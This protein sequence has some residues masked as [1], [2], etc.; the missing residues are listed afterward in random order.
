M[1]VSKNTNQSKPTTKPAINT[2]SS[3]YQQAA[4]RHNLSMSEA[5]QPYL[6]RKLALDNLDYS[7]R[8][9]RGQ[10]SAAE[11]VELLFDKGTFTEI[12]PLARES[13]LAANTKPSETPRDGIVVGYGKVNGRMVGAA[14]Y[15]IQFRGGSMGKVCEW[16]FTRLKRLIK[17]QGFPLVIMSEGTGARLEEEVSSQGAY[18]N[19]QFTNLVALSGYVPIV[20]AVMGVCVGGHA[21]LTAIG[22][23]VPMTENSSMMLAGPPLLRTKMGVDTTLEELGGARKHVEQSGMGDLLVKDDRECIEK[24][25]EFLGYLPNNCQEPAPQRH[26]RDNPERRCEALLEVVPS[27]LRFAYDIKKVVTEL[28][29]DGRFFEMQ[30]AFAPNVVTALAHMGGRAVGVIANQ[31][32]YMSG[33]IDVKAC[34]KISRFINFCDCFGIALVFLQDIPGFYPGPQSEADGIIRWSTR[35]LYEIGH[36]TVPRLTVMLRKAFGLA[37][38]GMNSLGMEPDLLVAWPLASFS[39]ISP[40]DAVEIMFGKQLAQ[41]EDGEQRKQELIAEFEAKTTILPAAEAALVDDVIDPRDTR[42]V[43]IKALEMAK[44]RRQGHTFKRRGITPI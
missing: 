20:V 3:V 8:H 12:A 30:P 16:K 38:Y 6:D 11:R 41:I 2:S 42:K 10:M 14:A 22:D 18:D 24:I 5:L 34:Q 29:D 4:G 36:T 23:F 25:K 17:E 9:A 33:T 26:S 15:D 1:S 43:L 19:P 28:V 21:N 39:A 40:D 31:P 37:H 35:L 27:D 7:K 32:A 44:N 13:D